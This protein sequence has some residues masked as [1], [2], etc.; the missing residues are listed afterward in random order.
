MS[1]P[2][3]SNQDWQPCRAGEISSAV[4]AARAAQRTQLVRR[5]AFAVAGVALVGIVSATLAL[6]ILAPESAGVRIVCSDFERL[7]DSYVKNQ[8]DS[9]TH[10]GME[11]HLA[12]CA[13]CRDFLEEVQSL[14]D[15]EDCA[16]PVESDETRQHHREPE[17]TL[18]GLYT[19]D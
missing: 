16:D 4:D 6:P 1:D 8:L 11:Q 14:Q 7:A 2:S 5:Q 10:E 9:S 3:T 13:N 17:V 12:H 15:G 18:A 19:A